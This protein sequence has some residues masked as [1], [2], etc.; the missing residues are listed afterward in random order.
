MKATIVDLRYNMK[1][2]LKALRRNEKVRVL[3]HGKETAIMIP[4]RAKHARKV[5]EHPFFG[6]STKSQSAVSVKKTMNQLRGR[7]HGDI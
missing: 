1:N 2:I 5:A 3:Y 6:M 7:R 4:S